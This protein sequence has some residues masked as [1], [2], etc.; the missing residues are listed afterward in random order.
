M[1]I[2]KANRWE[3]V[4]GVLRS[5]VL[6]TQ[7][8]S[9]GTRVTTTHNNSNWAEPSTAYRV[10]ITPTFANSMIILRYH[11]PVNQDSAANIL[12]NIRAFR[13]ISGGSKDFTLTSTGNVNGVRRPIAG[14][15]FRP[16]NGFDFNDQN[17]IS[18]DVI[19]FPNTTSAVTY[20]FESSPEGGNTTYWG[21]SN[22][23]NSQWGY[24]ADIV[25]V[26][27]EIAQ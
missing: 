24:D 25:I 18:L 8:V 26:A 19:D 12:T 7:H 14:G 9:S 6:Q 15:T 23:N 22:S 11:I 5:T 20:G 10:T 17:I 27:Q 4:N 21:F 3:T 2:I 13:I 1:S 16:G